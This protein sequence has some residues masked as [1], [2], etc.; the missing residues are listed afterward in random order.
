MANL[1]THR[2][3]RLDLR[4]ITDADID[5][6]YRLNSDPRVW[7]HFPSGV[8]TSRDR[9]AALIATFVDAWTRDGLGYWTVRPRGGHFVGVGGC[10]KKDDVA[11]NVYYRFQ[12]EAQGNGYAT[13]LVLAAIA[14]AHEVRPELPVC[15]F[16]LEHNVA[17][18]KVA[19]KS[20]LRLVW[21]G[22]DVSNP[23]PAAIRLVYADRRLGR[24]R[25]ELLGIAPGA[26]KPR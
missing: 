12:P 16:L 17:S 22:P 8:H 24:D 21:R 11:W 2:T 15:A 1:R 6:V 3:S 9:T 10:M 25:L 5:I 26:A 20:G 23:E 18:Q 4:A 19:E 13:E 14:A 7:S